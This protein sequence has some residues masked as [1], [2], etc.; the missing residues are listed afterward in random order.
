MG[1]TFEHIRGILDGISHQSRIGI[2]FDTC[3]AFSAGYDIV[4]KEGLAVLVSEIRKHLGLGSVKLIHLND[5]KK[6]L[7]SRVDRHE[8]IGEGQI[9]REGF[10]RF[11]GHP[12]FAAVPVI[13]ETPKKTEEDDPRNLRV[14]RELM[15]S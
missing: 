8:H 12:G 1:S 3:H 2:C 9:T 15:R 6:G 11:L 4:D 7:N 13:L 14:V 5:A 10:M